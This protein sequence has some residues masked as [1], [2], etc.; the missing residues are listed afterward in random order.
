[1]SAT[2][3]RRTGART[4][5]AR[6]TVADGERILYGQR[7]DGARHGQPRTRPRPRLSR[8]TRTR[9]RRQRGP[10]R[11]R[12][13]LPRPIRAAQRHPDGLLAARG[14]PREPAVSRGPRPSQSPL[15]D[16]MRVRVDQARP[17]RTQ[18][19]LPVSV[20][21]VVPTTFQPNVRYSSVSPRRTSI[22]LVAVPA[23]AALAISSN[24]PGSRGL[25]GQG[26]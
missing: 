13:R 11:P 10:V 6:Y 21:L 7:V 26:P 19:R 3:A 5:L 2:A 20:I 9:A 18:D 1:M 25:V 15:R 12:R 8:R 16:G 17:R 14:L 22:R 24:C 23:A 4:E